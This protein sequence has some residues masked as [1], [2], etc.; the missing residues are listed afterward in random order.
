[1]GFKQ[2][3]NMTQLM[4]LKRSLR[5]PHGELTPQAEAW[6]ERHPV[7]VRPHCGHPEL[8]GEEQQLHTG[9]HTCICHMLR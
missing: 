7:Q 5:Q 2:G 1:M 6:E 4:V 9:L 3:S 8:G